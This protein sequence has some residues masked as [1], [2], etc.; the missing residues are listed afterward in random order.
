[1]DNVIN[2]IKVDS[3]LADRQQKT[4]KRA[5]HTSTPATFAIAEPCEIKCPMMIMITPDIPPEASAVLAFI[6]ISA[7]DA[8]PHRMRKIP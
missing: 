6:P 8:M 7:T 3:V 4:T 2:P 5:R 1:M